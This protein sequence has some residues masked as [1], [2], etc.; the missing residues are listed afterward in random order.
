MVLA[1]EREALGLRELLRPELAEEAA[2][3]APQGKQ[4]TGIIEGDVVHVRGPW[5][6]RP[7]PSPCPLPRGRG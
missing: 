6:A 3:L 7:D 5:P 2:G 4:D 1:V